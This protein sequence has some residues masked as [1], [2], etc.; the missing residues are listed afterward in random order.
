MMTTAEEWLEI[1]ESTEPPMTPEDFRRIQG[2][3]LR[4]A[5]NWYV[6]A[7]SCNRAGI[8]LTALA[9]A[10]EHGDDINPLLDRVRMGAKKKDETPV[11]PSKSLLDI[12][13]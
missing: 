1:L 5:A 4:F 10:V 8:E 13:P 7:P 6:A 9:D 3:A 2:D 12:E 11:L